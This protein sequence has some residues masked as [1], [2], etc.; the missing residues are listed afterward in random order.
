[1]TRSI[2]V[3]SKTAAGTAVVAVVAA[4]VLREV[5]LPKLSE[6]GRIMR[7]G[8]G[9]TA[10]CPGPL[11]Q[12]GDRN[13]SLSVSAGTS[14]PVVLHCQ[15]GCSP[16]A[17]LAGI[18]LTFADLCAPREKTATDNDSWMP[19]GRTDSGYDNRH[20]K[21]AE[22]AYHDANGVLVFAV[23]RC[24]LKGAGCQGFRQWRP[25][26]TAK[27]GRRWSVTLP[28]GS[29]VGVGLPYRLPEVLRTQTV[30]LPPTVWVVEGEKD[31]DR[32]WSIGQPA[33]CCAGGA[34]KW[35]AEHAK[36]LAGADVI[37]CADR[38]KPG[39]AHAETVVETLMDTARSIEIVRAAQG[40]DISDHLDA[41][42]SHL[43]V[44]T[45]AEPKAPVWPCG[46]GF[47]DCP[48]CGTGEA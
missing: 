12:H 3:T 30:L 17:V 11:H 32:L 1:M 26:P 27:S 22:Y 23:A 18:G 42:L 5:V 14:Q 43:T 34:G 29:R 2:R 36:W 37:I 46:C 48:D 7:S 44:I 35:T 38:D 21:V 10:T 39:Y 19:C 8:G 13:P 28:D 24:A 40:K 45:I 33:T 4:D 6:L 9:F 41:G 31:A 15:A 16:D 47:A 20:R 25:D